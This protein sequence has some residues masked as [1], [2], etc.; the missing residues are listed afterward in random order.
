MIDPRLAALLLLSIAPAP[1]PAEPQEQ[2][3]PADP[4]AAIDAE[5]DR[6]F[7][8]LERER[9]EQLAA[10]AERSEGPEA[11]RAY[12]TYF[13]SALGAGL[14]QEAEELAH[15]VLEAGAPSPVLR[16]L[17]EVANV[18]AEADRGAFEESLTSIVRAV[19]ASEREGQ[20]DAQLAR[21]ALP[22]A[23]RLSLLDTYYQRLVQAGQYE[24]ARKAFG[25][26]RRNLQD[27]SEPEI[28]SYLENRIAQ[29]DM[30]G[31]PAPAFEGVDVDGRAIRSQDLAGQPVLLVFWATWYQ[32]NAE[33]IAWMKEAYGSYRER[34][35]R[36]IGVNLDALANGGR[37]L[38]EVLPEVREYVLR[39]N[40]PWPN[41]VNVPGDG[42]IARA[43]GI[44]EIPANVLIDGTGRIA[45]LELGPGTFATEVE[46]VLGGS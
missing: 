32:P 7:R 35:L 8:A 19:Q 25:T 28:V 31:Q 10:L 6:K 21:I 26:I 37:P 27:G 4:I 22:P 43:F 23:A 40:V 29:L 18:M 39:H 20:E 15:R 12:E 2:G 41:I 24:I 34:G 17:A 30:V 16:Y 9:L 1:T 13:R 33:Q 42:D 14:F 38:E 44:S 46:K 36:I 45:A 11:I 3:Q 5:F